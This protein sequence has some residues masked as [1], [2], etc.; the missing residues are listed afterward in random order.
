MRTLLIA[1]L[2]LLPIS[3]FAATATYHKKLHNAMPAAA[4]YH[5]VTGKKLHN[6]TKAVKAKAVK[7]AKAVK[8]AKPKA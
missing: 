8:S 3:A 5:P 1:A 7:P 6:A 4:M 2:F